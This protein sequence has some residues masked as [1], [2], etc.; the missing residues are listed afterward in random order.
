M[1]LI[2]WLLY[3]VTDVY[4]HVGLKI[5]TRENDSWMALFSFW[6]IS[7]GLAWIVSALSWMFILSKNS[8]L[9]ANTVSAITY[10]VTAVAAAV[11]FKEQL[12]I[13]NV[14]G[15]M[16]VFIGIYLVAS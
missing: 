10:I 8:F 5:A 15:V 7:A 12:T 9:T 11:V 1:Q 14:I 16:F 4:G 13:R 2:A 3:F 6:G